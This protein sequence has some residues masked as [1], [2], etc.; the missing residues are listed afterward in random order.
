LKGKST[1]KYSE[2]PSPRRCGEKVTIKRDLKIVWRRGTSNM[3]TPEGTT[4]CRH[5]IRVDDSVIPKN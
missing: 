4:V 2:P 1:R 5:K 3:F